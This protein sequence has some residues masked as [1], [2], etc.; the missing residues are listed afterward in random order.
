[1]ALVICLDFYGAPGV[2]R[3]DYINGWSFFLVV[4]G[5]ERLRHRDL[6]FDHA[7]SPYSELAVPSKN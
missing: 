1:M 2:V 3:H 5:F 7:A 4:I 6:E